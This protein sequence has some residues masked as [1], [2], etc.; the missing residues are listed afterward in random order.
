[1]ADQGTRPKR[2]R[3]EPDARIYRD[4]IPHQSDPGDVR[5]RSM[6]YVAGIFFTD[7]GNDMRSHIHPAYGSSDMLLH[8]EETL[9]AQ[10]ALPE[11]NPIKGGS[12]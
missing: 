1:M 2:M 8:Q 11:A 5:Y 3:T 12:T 4:H 10:L 6:A 7:M 9:L